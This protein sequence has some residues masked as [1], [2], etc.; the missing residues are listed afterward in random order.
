MGV[1]GVAVTGI[2]VL[3]PCGSG[4]EEFWRGLRTEPGP[5]SQ[6]LRIDDFDPSPWLGPKEARRLDRFTQLAV[7][8][9]S[10]ALDDAALAGH[11]VEPA[12]AGV[13]V[14]TGV[15]G[16]ASYDEQLR[17]LEE[18]GP[19]R[20]SPF[21]I[22]MLMPNA[23]SAAVSMRLGWKGPCE[24]ITTAC[25]AGTHGVANAMRWIQ[26]GRCDIVLAGASE[27]YPSPVGIAAF[28]NMTALS[29]QGFSRPFDAE[30]DGFVA[31]EG[32]ALLVLEELEGARARGAHIY[33]V[34]LG[35]ASNADAHHLTA[36]SEAGEG[37]LACM[38]LALGDA[39]L[40]PG[41]VA[42]VNAHGTS[43]ML[44]DAAEASAITA[45]FGR[46]GPPVTSIKG[47]VG[48]PFGAAGA[49]EAAAVALTIDR[50]EIPPTAGFRTADP[51]IVV[52]VVA[53][54][55]RSFTPG[56]VLS[57]S[58]AFGGHNGCLV[59]APPAGSL[60]SVH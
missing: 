11:Q 14:A 16:L 13:L 5:R 50:S 9:A 15:G 26:S 21:L 30:R 45:L 1:A 41:D 44:N 53:G 48:H 7:A 49:L 3:A 23:G 55:P 43:T 40:G 32:A 24:T 60:P 8:A 27:A 22:P 20:V 33:A 35:A 37:A 54:A 18:R 4:V 10:M 58:F 28:G 17:V 2:G 19:K 6:P 57:N 56:P 38:R 12:R 52:D 29:P 46:P 47:V 42:H 36:P 25:A 31:S 51:A 34:V 59:M 39:G